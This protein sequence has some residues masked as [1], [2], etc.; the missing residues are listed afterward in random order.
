M[1]RIIFFLLTFTVFLSVGSLVYSLAIN[2]LFLKKKIKFIIGFNILINSVV[3]VLLSIFRSLGIPSTFINYYFGIIAIAFGVGV[4][5]WLSYLIA[6][7]KTKNIWH[8]K[9]V[10]WLIVIIFLFL[11]VFSIVSFEKPISINEYEIESSK[12]SKNY[13]FV[14]FA[15]TQ[16]GSMSQNY[17]DSVNKLVSKQNVD[18][19]IFAGDL[20]DTDYYQRENFASLELIEKQIYFIRGNHELSHDEEKLLNIL[21]TF[22]NIEVLIDKKVNIEEIEII[23]IDYEDNSSHIINQMN[24]I[25]RNQESFSVLATHHPRDFEYVLD[26]GFDLLVAG[27]THA[28]QIWPM[29]WFVNYLYTYDSGYYTYGESILYTTSG[30]GLW[31]PRMRLGSENEIV[32]FKIIPK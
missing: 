13:S 23:G 29:N 9:K 19:V 31:G 4:F 26:E 12:V 21:S 25:E 10:R 22:S 3:V 18:F 32:I 6:M 8:N 14:L 20:I 1:F 11:I 5:F 30:V 15:D 17:F 28:G 24:S 7:I 27:H 2:K 16:F